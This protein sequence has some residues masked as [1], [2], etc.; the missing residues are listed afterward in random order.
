MTYSA[1][2]R[3]IVMDE[4]Q[5]Q[6]WVLRRLGAPILKVELHPAHLDDLVEDAKDWFISKKGVARYRLIDVATNVVEYDVPDDCDDVVEVLLPSAPH[7]FTMVFSPYILADEKIPYDVFAAPESAGLYSSLAQAIQ[8]TEMAKRVMSADANW[9]WDEY[10][11]KVILSPAPRTSGQ[12]M[13]VYS[14]ASIAFTELRH[15]DHQLVR[16]HMLANAK[17]LVGRIR[18]KYAG[19]PGAQ[20]ERQLDGRDIL[21]EGQEEMRTLDE[22]IIKAGMPMPFITG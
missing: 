7:D 4:E 15:F 1:R 13:L 16:R 12:M 2:S 22:D 11:R 5:L 6:K 21:S 3:Q 18:S 17:I 8:Y 19:F 14:S 9:I 20:G 10:T